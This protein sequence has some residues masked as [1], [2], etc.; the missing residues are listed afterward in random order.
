M[1]HFGDEVGLLWREKG[2]SAGTFVA[3]HAIPWL[4]NPAVESVDEDERELERELRRNAS[5]RSQLAGSDERIAEI[6]ARIAAKPEAV[7]QFERGEGLPACLVP[8]CEEAI[9][10]ELSADAQGVLRAAD[11][12]VIPALRALLV[13]AGL[14]VESTTGYGDGVRLKVLLPRAEIDNLPPQP[15]RESL[16]QNLANAV[17]AFRA[18]CPD[19]KKVVVELRE[20]IARVLAKFGLSA[21]PSKQRPETGPCDDRGSVA[22]SHFQFSPLQPA[23]P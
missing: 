15:T 1:Q 13:K 4:H 2:A 19:R 12:Q 21:A 16:R 23:A 3:G 7:A 18:S 11:M 8:K 22:A 9:R 17:E 14:K 6:R 10:K 5:L 20:A